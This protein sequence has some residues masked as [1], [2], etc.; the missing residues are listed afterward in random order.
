MINY[1]IS[2]S[3]KFLLEYLILDIKEK[4]YENVF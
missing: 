1:K 4:L 2:K 3:I